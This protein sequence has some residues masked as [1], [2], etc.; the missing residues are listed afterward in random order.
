MFEKR[1][2]AELDWVKKPG[3]SPACKLVLAGV[4]VFSVA[5]SVVAVVV[6][7]VVVVAAAGTLTWVAGAGF[8]FGLD[9]VFK[10]VLE[11]VFKPGGCLR[12]AFFLMGIRVSAFALETGSV[13][14]GTDALVGVG[15]ARGGG[16][17]VD[18]G[19]CATDR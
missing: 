19:G 10:C 9:N 14:L 17:A 6:V 3:T 5:G 2:A 16:G 12:S 15:S 11:E 1:L 18:D 8:G 7:V 13:G 4:V